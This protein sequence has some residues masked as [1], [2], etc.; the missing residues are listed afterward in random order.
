MNLD[1][2]KNLLEQEMNR[3]EFLKLAGVVILGLIGIT[4]ALNNLQDIHRSTQRNAKTSTGYGSSAYG[5]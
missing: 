3:K 4:S 5:R 2:V 1:A